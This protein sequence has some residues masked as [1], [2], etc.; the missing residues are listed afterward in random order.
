MTCNGDFD[1]L[2]ELHGCDDDNCYFRGMRL[3]DV[4]HLGYVIDTFERHPHDVRLKAFT[5]NNQAYAL[6]VTDEGDDEVVVGVAWAPGLMELL[7]D[8]TTSVRPT[9][10]VN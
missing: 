9:R 1:E 6:L 2:T 8:F 5:Y 4:G 7:R 10:V 3:A